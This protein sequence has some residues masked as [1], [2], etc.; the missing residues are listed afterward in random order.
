[1]KTAPIPVVNLPGASVMK[2]ILIV[3]DESLI[4]DSLS[5]ALR[6]DDTYI[7]AVDCGKDALGEI[8]HIFYN[9]CFL[10]VNLPDIN[11]LDLMKTIKKSSPA[12][13]ITIMTAGVVDEPAMMHSIQENASLFL[14]K[15]FELDRVK[16]FVDQIIGKETSIRLSEEQSYCER[17]PFEYQPMDDKRQCER[18]AVMPGTTCSVVALDGEQGD[19]SFIA[20]ILEISATGVCIRTKNPLKPGQFLRFNDNPVLRRGVVRWSRGGGGEGSYCSGIQFVMPEYQP[21]S[22]SYQA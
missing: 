9:L 7:K 11:G 16:L 14:T 21:E 15:P 10:D 19:R 2:R 13:K 8:N 22:P 1:M 17:E 4:R 5:S 18:E 12:T 6:R 20:G 3:D